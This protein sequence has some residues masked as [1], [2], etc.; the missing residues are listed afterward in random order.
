MEAIEQDES[1]VAAATA[2]PEAAD[3]APALDVEAIKAEVAGVDIGKLARDEDES[4]L[5]RY[6]RRRQQ[7]AMEIAGRKL[8]KSKIKSIKT[9]FG[10]VGFRKVNGGI[11]VTD[12]DKLIALAMR[13][14]AYKA[15][16]RVDVNLQ[17]SS[18][19]DHFKTSGEIPP[20][21]ELGADEERFFVK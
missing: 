18:I 7:V 5:L 6:L 12:E 4:I 19:N 11:V 9:P 3:A 13:D 10:Q 1:Q 15:L 16:I 2:E 17:K 20:F 14:K 21:C 8:A